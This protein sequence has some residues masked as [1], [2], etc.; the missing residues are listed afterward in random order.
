MLEY[1]FPILFAATP[2]TV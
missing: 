2:A 1:R